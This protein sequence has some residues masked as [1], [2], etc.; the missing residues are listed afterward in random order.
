MALNVDIQPLKKPPGMVPFLCYHVWRKA[1][2]SGKFCGILIHNTSLLIQVD[3]L[4]LHLCFGSHKKELYQEA[5]TECL[6]A[7]GWSQPFHL[8]SP[9]DMGVS[10][11][12]MLTTSTLSSSGIFAVFSSCSILISYYSASSGVLFP[13][14]LLGCNLQ[15]PETFP[16]LVDA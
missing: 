15:K 2:E 1:T 4:S 16:T 14:K 12:W 11:R 13:E 8:S 7:D 10:V 6:P 9:P 3:E 5:L